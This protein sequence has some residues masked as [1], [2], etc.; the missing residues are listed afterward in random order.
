M[1]NDRLYEYRINCH[2]GSAPCNVHQMRP[3]VGL[4]TP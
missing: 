3:V 1:N 4:V 2:E